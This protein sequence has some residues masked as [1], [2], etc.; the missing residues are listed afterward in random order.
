[1]NLKLKARI[2]EA[3]I[4]LID[5][6]GFMYNLHKME[7]KALKDVKILIPTFVDISEGD[8]I[9]TEDWKLVLMS[10]EQPVDLAVRVGKYELVSSDDFEPSMYLNT[11]ITGIFLT[12]DKCY[13]KTVGPDKKP[14]YMATLKIKDAKYGPYDMLAVAFGDQ[15]KKLSTVPRQSTLQCEATLKRRRNNPGFELAIVNFRVKTEGK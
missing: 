6:N 11:R 5:Y 12:S 3:N 7:L 1:M 13:L 2:T 10:N 4:E 15:A 14:F 9:E 8:C